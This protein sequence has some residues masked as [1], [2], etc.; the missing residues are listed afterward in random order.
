MVWRAAPARQADK[1][2]E[3]AVF[4]TIMRFASKGAARP[5]C[6]QS[7]RTLVNPGVP[8]LMN[9]CCVRTKITNEGG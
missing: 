1:A 9:S 4:S 6:A 3:M 7:E 8:R 2:L 5:A